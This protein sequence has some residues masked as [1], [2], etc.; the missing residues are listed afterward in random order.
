[1]NR[2]PHPVTTLEKALRELGAKPSEGTDDERA[3]EASALAKI[4]SMNR[5]QR[6][7]LV[8]QARRTRGAK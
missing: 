2:N 6:R 1:M 5:K 3:A 4:G 7:A 8:A